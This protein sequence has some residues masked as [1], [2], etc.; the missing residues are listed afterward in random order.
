MH[1]VAFCN[2]LTR[3]WRCL[4]EG[5]R[6]SACRGNREF[7]S[8]PLNRRRHQQ[9]DDETHCHLGGSLQVEDPRRHSRA[10]SPLLWYSDNSEPP[11]TMRTVMGKQ[12]NKR[13]TPKHVAFATPL[14]QIM[15]DKAKLIIE[16]SSYNLMD[17]TLTTLPLGPSIYSCDPM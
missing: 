15:V 14:T 2:R 12:D 13:S 8:Q 1:R 16:D 9:G 4:E 11:H 7:L 3:C 17:N 10:S 6:A 5:H